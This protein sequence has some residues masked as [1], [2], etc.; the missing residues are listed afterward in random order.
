V[1][2]NTTDE[3]V[4]DA[5]AQTWLPAQSIMFPPPIAVTA[6]EPSIQSPVTVARS[7][8]RAITSSLG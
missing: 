6:P 4:S 2:V 7:P 3:Q 5:K 1:Y 8:E